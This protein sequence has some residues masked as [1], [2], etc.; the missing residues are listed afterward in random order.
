M[1]RPFESR[2]SATSIAQP[3]HDLEPQIV[4]GRAGLSV[5]F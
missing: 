5:S 1:D 3:A 2:K 4:S